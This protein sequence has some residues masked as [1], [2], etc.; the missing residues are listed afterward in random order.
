MKRF[1]A[2][3]LLGILTFNWFGYQLYIAIVEDKENN[4]LE[5]RLDENIYDESELVSIKI[6]AT[7]LPYYTNSKAFERVDGQVEIGGIQYKYVKRRMFNDCLELLCIPNKTSIR[8]QAA[9]DD[10]F[11]T[12]NDLQAGTQT[13]KK[14]SQQNSSKNFSFECRL[15]NN[16]VLA[17]NCSHDL[18]KRFD[19]YRVHLP[20]A[21]LSSPE[22]PPENC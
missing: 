16:I 9:K 4:K 2:I 21:L 5:T 7:N 13:G 8:L 17:A 11:K 19:G 14:G 1:A 22:Q 10:Y 3:L 6:P 20:S 15:E 18:A 12:V